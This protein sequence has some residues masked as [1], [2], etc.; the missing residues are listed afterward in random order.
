MPYIHFLKPNYTIISSMKYLFLPVILLFL[1]ACTQRTLH[2]KTQRVAEVVLEP[3]TLKENDY[4][5][6][7]KIF[8]TEC[9]L[10]K[11]QKLYGDL[12]QKV[13]KIQDKE[14]FIKQNFQL[15]RL[16][17]KNDNIGLLTG[18][19]EPM[20]FG[21]L[22]KHYPFVY[23]VYGVPKDLI[24][25]ELGSIYP[26]IKHLRLRGRLKGNKLVPYYTRKEQEQIK[27]KPICYVDDKVKLFLLEVQGSGRIRLDDGRMLYVGYADQN[28]HRYASIGK[29][30]IQKGYIKRKDLSL[31]SIEIFLKTHPQKIDEVLNY[32]DSLVFFRKKNKPA[33]GALGLELQAFRSVAVDP[34]FIP[35]GAMLYYKAL[36]KD[37]EGIVFAQD[38]GGAIKG[39]VR[40]DLFTGYGD[41]AREVAG[42][43]K[44][45]LKLWIFLPK[46]E[47]DK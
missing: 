21:S 18:Y 23:P 47:D 38:T 43:L 16:Q 36:D 13:Q 26:Q 32:N 4:A 12:C 34:S 6:V 17:N 1:S 9:R 24:R 30:M 19:Y 20:L 11:V 2:L 8:Q 41:E 22:K 35:L 28:G 31:R 15:Y 46:K 40:A 3:V 25:V 44:S 29:Y 10:S 27:A 7:G 37:L 39:N 5:E 14:K 33:T 45:P 42:N